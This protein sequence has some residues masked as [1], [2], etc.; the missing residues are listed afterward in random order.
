MLKKIERACALT[1]LKSPASTQTVREDGR[2]NFTIHK[3]LTEKYSLLYGDHDEMSH[4]IVVI[5]ILPQP[6]CDVGVAGVEVIGRNQEQI[7]LLRGLYKCSP[8]DTVTNLAGIHI[9]LRFKRTLSTKR[10]KL[11]GYK[12]YS[13]RNPENSL[14]L[15][16]IAD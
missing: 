3:N 4:N 10:W 15:Y 2:E 7:D 11:F 13:K 6:D 9:A 14:K 16:Q 8:K 12:K 5:P 1:T